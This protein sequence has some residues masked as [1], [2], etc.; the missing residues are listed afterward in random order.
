MSRLI[1]PA[2]YARKQP[3]RWTV[4][5]ARLLTDVP[6]A[7]AL[8]RA[9]EEELNLKVQVSNAVIRYMHDM[10]LRVA[11]GQATWPAR[12][13]PLRRG[14]RPD[15]HDLR[16]EPGFVGAADHRYLPGSVLRQAFRPW[17]RL[18]EDDQVTEPSAGASS[19]IIS[20]VRC[21]HCHRF[22]TSVWDDDAQR[23]AWCIAC[24]RQWLVDDLVGV[25][26]PWR[27]VRCGADAGDTGATRILSES[28]GPD[29]PLAVH[30]CHNCGP[31]IH[32]LIAQLRISVPAD[33]VPTFH[34]IKGGRWVDPFDPES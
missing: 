8:Y 23:R 16:R 26:C 11:A 6:T 2:S 32:A 13:R 15:E 24:Q 10:R 21:P 28:D 14:R 9:Q 18:R 3:A 30:H 29:G 34:V 27:C 25:P 19:F 33:Q 31:T 4:A 20:R 1:V 22:G 5:D 12:E 17:V 7:F